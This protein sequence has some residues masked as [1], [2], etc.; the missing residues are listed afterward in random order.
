MRGAASSVE[1]KGKPGA[2]ALRMLALIEV[3]FLLVAGG[4]G[5]RGLL[6]VLNDTRDRDAATVQG[7]LEPRPQE[8]LK[9]V[10]AMPVNTTQAIAGIAV[11]TKGKAAVPAATP[12]AQ[13][14]PGRADTKTAGQRSK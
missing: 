6:E 3:L 2:F 4:L 10:H 1:E 7:Y 12:P 11:K 9:H 8:E 5:V 13:E 14:R